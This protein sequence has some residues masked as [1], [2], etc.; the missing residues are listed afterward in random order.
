MRK[1]F[2]KC[3]RSFSV[4]RRDESIHHNTHSLFTILHCSRIVN[5]FFEGLKIFF[6]EMN[7]EMN[8]I[9]TIYDSRFSTIRKYFFQ[10]EIKIFMIYNRTIYIPL[11]IAKKVFLFFFSKNFSM[12][13]NQNWETKILINRRLKITFVKISRNTSQ[14]DQ[15]ENGNDLERG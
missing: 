13:K 15:M 3:Y 12:S 6:F 7:I 4:S 14:L 11:I 2:F 8:I 9:S 1:F 5:A 10:V